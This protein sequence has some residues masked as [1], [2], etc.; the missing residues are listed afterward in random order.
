MTAR[1]PPLPALRAFAAFIRLGSVQAA[2]EA[3][4]LTPGA[5]GHQIRALE[6]VLQLPLLERQG[7]RMILTEHG[8]LYGYQIRQALDDIASATESTALKGRTRGSTRVV[9]V[10]LLPSWAQGWLLPRLP[11]FCRQF[12]QT[13]L[14]FHGSMDYV[15]LGA[16]TVDCAIRFGHGSW[17]DA[18]VRPLMGDRLMV[19]AAPKLLGKRPPQTVEQLL[20]LP[21]LQ[22][23]ESWASWLSSLPAPL[24]DVQRP[25]ARLEFTDS[26]HLLEAARLGLGIALSRRSIADSLLERG[27]LVPAFDHDCPHASSYYALLPKTASP[28][29]ATEQFL[30][31]LQTEC[32]R[33]FKRRA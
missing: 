15:D 13:R 4:S 25:A 22:S 5:V 11:S 23:Q 3:L 17:P 14:V 32:A 21:L 12:P 18:V 1:I 29:E 33:F 19:L 30:G 10:S 6:E 27:E 2:A 20:R 24:N 16:G 8:L 28:T 31:W 7:R 9:R 26:T